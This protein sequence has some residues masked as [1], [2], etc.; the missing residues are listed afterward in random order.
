LA[1]NGLVVVTVNYRLGRLGYLAHPA[2]SAEGPT[3]SS[4]N[5]GL[6]DQIAALR[7]VRENIRAFG[8]DPDAV[9]LAGQSAGAMSASA[10]MAVPSAAGL[11][12]RVAL[13]SGATFG[14][15]GETARTGDAMQRLDAAERSG[16]R[17][18]TA[19]GARTVDELREIPPLPLQ[20]AAVD[21]SIRPAPSPRPPGQFDTSWLIVDGELLPSGVASVFNA[22]R[23]AAVPMLSGSTAEDWSV[24]PPLWAAATGGV[25]VNARTELGENYDEFARLFP[26]ESQLSA[27]RAARQV[28]GFRNFIWQNF[29]AARAHSAIGY[30]AWHYRFEQVPPLPP[31]QVFAENVAEE[32][33]AYHTSDL[34]YLF[35]TMSTRPWKWT[36]GDRTI[37]DLMTRYWVRFASSGDPNGGADARWPQFADSAPLTMRLGAGSNAEPT[38]DLDR[39]HLWDT[40]FSASLVQ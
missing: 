3:R 23:Q 38:P 11:F 34:Y 26:H 17:F 15:V 14:P 10:L 18:A 28:V 29:A 16:A 22:G 7:W 4:G 6:M 27:D 32:L 35:G 30:Q 24:M 13:H 2:L 12:H 31:G 25:E 33:G 20:I 1:R 8:G 5:Y 9:T 21:G 36:D 37:S 39:I 19:F 40:Y